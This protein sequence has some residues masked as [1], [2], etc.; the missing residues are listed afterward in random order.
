MGEIIVNQGNEYH[1]DRRTWGGDYGDWSRPYP[2][3][4]TYDAGWTQQQLTYSN[5]GK[6]IVITNGARLNNNGGGY[7]GL[8]YWRCE[9]G[10]Q[11]NAY[12]KRVDYNWWKGGSKFEVRCNPQRWWKVYEGR[13]ERRDY[14]TFNRNINTFKQRYDNTLI[15]LSNEISEN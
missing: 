13:Y 5:Y 14:A 2:N 6:S 15:D 1:G 9:R 8:N 4:N 7:K 12:D 3:H 11:L 10:W